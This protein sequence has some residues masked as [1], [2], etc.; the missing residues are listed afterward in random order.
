MQPIISFYIRRHDVEINLRNIWIL[1]Y[2]TSLFGSLASSQVRH[3][4][5]DFA[6][7]HQAMQIYQALR[8]KATVQNIAKIGLKTAWSIGMLHI[9][10]N[11]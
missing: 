2:M 6:L 3:T 10:D 1:A 7:I 9:T 4:P 5:V 8:Q 11:T